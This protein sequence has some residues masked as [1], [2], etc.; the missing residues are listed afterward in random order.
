MRNLCDVVVEANGISLE[1]PPPTENGTHTNPPESTSQPAPPSA[2][3]LA[4]INAQT[5]EM[6][7]QEYCT[8]SE[9]PEKIKDKVS[10]VFNNLS[11]SNMTEKIQLLRETVG[12]EHI[13]WLANYVVVKRAAQE[14]NFHP[15]YLRLVEEMDNKSLVDHII[16][17]TY[18]YVKVLLEKDRIKHEMSDRSLLKNLGSWL[19]QLTIAK[20]KPVRQKDMDLKAIMFEAYEKGKMVAVIPFV[21]KVLEQGKESKVYGPSN[22]WIKGILTLLAEIYRLEGLKM[23]LTFEIEMIFKD[24]NL[25]IDEIP[26]S[27]SLDG[28]QRDNNSNPDFYDTRNATPSSQPPANVPKP[29][30][31]GPADVSSQ[32]SPTESAGVGVSPQMVTAPG[33]R[34]GGLDSVNEPVP[35]GPRVGANMQSSFKQGMVP[36]MNASVG[37][38]QPPVVATDAASIL[39]AL[40][41]NLHQL[42]T[43]NPTLS[44]L[45]QT[46]SR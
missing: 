23:N 40:A 7:A 1:R 42:V 31:S 17:T 5:L 4:A 9:P 8:F 25:N 15:L 18:H 6:A 2:P 36:S 26:A 45:A 32:P 20:N 16:Q 35:P 27:K 39:S 3:S 46:V 44:A 22:P 14:V 19:G 12:D 29:G 43:I 24:F 21:H 37:G 34:G 30:L 28:I 13:Q 33:I 41:G 11:P 38:V 10:F